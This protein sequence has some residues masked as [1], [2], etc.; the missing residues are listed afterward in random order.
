MSD[1]MGWLIAACVASVAAYWLGKKSAQ[2]GNKN[3]DLGHMEDKAPESG[4]FV[5]VAAMLKIDYLD[6]KRDRTERRVRVSRFSDVRELGV[7]KSYCYL[8]SD[9]RTFRIDRILSCVDTETGEIVSDVRAYLRHLAGLDS[10]NI[11]DDEPVATNSQLAT[12]RQTDPDDCLERE[13]P[14]LFRVLLFVAMEEG[15]IT[16]SKRKIIASYLRRVFGEDRVGDGTVNSFARAQSKPTLM[17]FKQAVGRVVNQKEL[18][19]V[20]MAGCCRY[21]AEED[22]VISDDERAALEYLDRR[23]M[24]LSETR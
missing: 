24:S 1:G 19:P 18:N 21:V 8:R 22:S 13:Y 11:T 2:P 9:Y 7:L 20:L 17:S 12:T 23:V 15:K 16:K 5:P 3:P 6:A 10:L 4:A 14:D